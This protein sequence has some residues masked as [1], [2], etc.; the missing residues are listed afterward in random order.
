[1]YEL[2]RGPLLWIA[3]GVFVLGSLYKLNALRGRES[4]PGRKSILVPFSAKDVGQHPVIA[5]ASFAFTFCLLF[6][7]LFV[8]G[9]AVSW[10]ESWGIRW[11]SMPE[12]AAAILTLIAIVGCLFLMLQRISVPEI[13]D[14]STWGDWLL[15]LLV[16][17]PFLTGFLAYYQVLPYK[18]MVILH[19]VSGALWLMALPFTRLFRLVW[20]GFGSAYLEAEFDTPR[21]GGDDG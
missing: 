7:P 2:A 13:R 16:V 15:L 4:K 5:L 8:F 14:L 10:H 3:F 20:F 12:G 17:A 19:L 6:T 18:V 1:M 21:G 11:W 9:H